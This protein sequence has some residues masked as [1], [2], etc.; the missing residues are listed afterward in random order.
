MKNCYLPRQYKI[1]DITPQT[2]IDYTYRVAFD[3]PVI[4][5]QF[6]EVSIPG[7]GEAPIS[8]SDFGEGYIDMTIRKVG[9]VTHY[10][11]T[12]K[13]GDPLYLRGPYGNGFDLEKYKQKHLVLAAGGTGLAPIKSIINYFHNHPNMIAHLDLLIGFKSSKDILFADE[14][15]KWQQNKKFRL[16][17]TIDGEE[18]N[19]Q[20]NVGLIT[21]YVPEIS[22]EKNTEVI[23]VGPPLMMKFTAMA[24]LEKTSE[25]KIWVSF[26]RKM[27]CG[28]GKCGHCK[29]DETYVCLEGPVFNYTKAKQLI[30]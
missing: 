12:L 13:V 3:Q 30:D 7:I 26:E 2:A 21:K 1:I 28:I 25:E 5:G 8:I 9:K 15:K 16:L 14:I 19:W 24:F 23:I 20:G 4:G 22:I 10:L 18:E 6:V 29:I 11:N 17:L 27:S